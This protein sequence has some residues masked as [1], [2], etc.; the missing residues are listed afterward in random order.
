MMTALL[1]LIF[2]L[3]VCGG[4]FRVNLGESLV[5]VGLRNNAMDMIILCAHEASDPDSPRHGQFYSFDDV[6]Q[7]AH[8]PASLVAVRNYLAHNTTL[9]VHIREVSND[10]QWLSL[11]TASPSSLS[12]AL[13]RDLEEHVTV[14][15]SHPR[16]GVTTSKKLTAERR[17]YQDIQKQKLPPSKWPPG[18]PVT[19]YL[20]LSAIKAIY[21]VTAGGD[22]G[23]EA[24]TA[25]VFEVNA[26]TF[27]GSIVERYN[28][29]DLETFEKL[30]GLQNS[31]AIL[32]DGD[33]VTIGCDQYTCAEPMLDV[34]LL[35]GMASVS[36]LFTQGMQLLVYY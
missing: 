25:A 15:I 22:G 2:S 12:E 29:A 10:K 16:V 34:E 33:N 30:S 9:N 20:S 5:E 7:M 8:N 14:V 11:A 19:P 35:R 17:H 21:N 32:F 4:A 18:P 36:N 13:R 6:L 26:L 31:P 28:P 24:A 27:D 3:F 1:G 23:G